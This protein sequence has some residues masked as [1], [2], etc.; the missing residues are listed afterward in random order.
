MSVIG[1][2][3]LSSATSRAPPPSRPSSRK[4]SRTRFSEVP[5]LALPLPLVHECLTVLRA[6]TAQHVPA[7][8]KALDAYVAHA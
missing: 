1:L 5:E 8:M 3:P 6:F 2:S 7:R 4:G